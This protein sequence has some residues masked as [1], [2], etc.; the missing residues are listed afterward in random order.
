MKALGFGL[1]LA[2]PLVGC[3]SSSD[4]ESGKGE[5]PNVVSFHADLNVAVGDETQQ[6]KL[7]QMP[8]D[9]GE[10]AVSRIHHEYTAGSHHFLL[11][12]TNLTEIPEGRDVLAPCNEGTGSWMRDVR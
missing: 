5:D 10:L 3:S 2:L 6:C 7:V 4:D 11:F 8:A 9:R 12:R 1:L